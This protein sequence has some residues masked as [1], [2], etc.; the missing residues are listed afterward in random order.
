MQHCRAVIKVAFIGAGSIEFTRNVVTDLCS[1]PEL[2]GNLHLALHDI[3]P[4]RLAFAEALTRQIVAQTGAG[5]TVTRVR[6]TRPGAGRRRLRHQRGAGRRATRRRWPTSRSR[7]ATASGRRS[8]TP[9]ASAGSS[10]ACGRSRWS[11][12][13]PQ[14]HAALLP[15]RLPAQLLQPDGDA[16]LGGLRRDRL[17]Q[18]VRPVPLGPRHA[19]VPGRAGRRGPGAASSSSRPASTTRR[20]CCV[21]SRTAS[22]C[23]RGWTR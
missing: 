23:T 9:S 4:D 8:A 21:S 11:P 10:A 15:G 2:A 12:R 13:W 5:A 20:S 19:R 22:R 3:S 17:Q 7:P 14:R 6:R 16:A 1:Y 18:R